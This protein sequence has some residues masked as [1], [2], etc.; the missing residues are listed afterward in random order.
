MEN[1]NLNKSIIIEV[2][3]QEAC[4]ALVVV[5]FLPRDPLSV[6]KCGVERVGSIHEKK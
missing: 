2:K 5:I 3:N 6:E 4:S 1:F